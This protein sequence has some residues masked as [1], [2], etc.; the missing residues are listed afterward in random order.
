MAHFLGFLA[1][2]CIEGL[3]IWLY[4]S[5]FTPR[6]RFF[7]RIILLSVSYLSL[8]LLS[9]LDLKWMNAVLYLSA[10]FL[11]LYLC[12]RLKWYGAL[13]HS[14]LLTSVMAM[15]ELMVYSIMDRFAPH[16]YQQTE[17]FYLSFIYLISSK[18]PFLLTAFVFALA[19]GK[20]KAGEKSEK[21]ALF[22]IAV[23]F[24]SAFAMVLFI[25]ILENYVLSDRMKQM[26]C[27]AAIILLVANIVM[28]V[29]YLYSQ[30]K[31]EEYLQTRL[32]LLREQKRSE[33]YKMIQEQND[34][35]RI[36][37]HDLK[38]H[39]STLEMYVTAG[40]NEKAH[41]YIREMFHF[42]GFKPSLVSSDND[43]LNAILAGYR[44]ECENWGIRIDAD[45]RSHSVDFL[46]ENDLTT[47]FGNILD[48][49]MEAAKGV[50]DGYIDLYVYREDDTPFLVV[51]AINSCECNPFESDGKTLRK[52]SKGEGLHGYGLK[53]IRQI[54]EK[55]NG[56]MEMHYD[57]DNN[58]F[59][60]TLLL[61]S[62]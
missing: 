59:Q 56:S 22:Y 49:A 31:N 50:K 8:A 53:S 11:F 45:I 1:G 33:Y 42:D 58:C 62:T 60:L 2:Y 36:L 55:Y 17:N 38:N 35:Q 26:I 57:G 21:G 54:L 47:L 48:N 43:L 44:R 12:F 28:F 9:P 34:N 61:D 24:S 5:V 20:I 39:L 32:H 4:S 27:L 46:S 16:F 15:Y 7:E 30:R 23:P 19:A 40:D 37:L 14:I 10:N 25:G 6:K 18:F 3:A 13:F 41:E 52:T 51:R 29:A